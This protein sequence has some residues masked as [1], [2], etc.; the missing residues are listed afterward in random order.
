[1]CLGLTP[2]NMYNNDSIDNANNNYY[3]YCNANNCLHIIKIIIIRITNY[4][5]C[6]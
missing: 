1:M 5:G 6:I 4:T 3:Y 2:N